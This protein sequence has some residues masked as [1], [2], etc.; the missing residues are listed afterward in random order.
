VQVNGQRIG[1]VHVWSYAGYS[2][3]R[4]LEHLIAEGAL[5]DADSLTWDLRDGWG[6]AIPEYLDLFNAQAPTMQVTD[7]NGAHE[8]EDV[9]WRKPVAIWSMAAPVAART[10]SHMVSRSIAWE[11]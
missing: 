2:Y 1:Y 9:K 6:D 11:R 3:Q 4:A 8:F 10:S 7:R 5:K